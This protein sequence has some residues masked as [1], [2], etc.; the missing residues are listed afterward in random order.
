MMNT[1]IQLP[2]VSQPLCRSQ[3]A[4]IN[5][6]HQ[7]RKR[8]LT[9]WEV[10]KDCD[11]FED[12]NSN[13]MQWSTAVFQRWPFSTAAGLAEHFLLRTLRFL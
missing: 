11:E 13:I 6:L 7:L 8:I 9:H 5:I 3:T 2:E 4:L 12:S 1:G 10:P